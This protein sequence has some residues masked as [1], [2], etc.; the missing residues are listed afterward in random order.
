MT[1]WYCQACHLVSFEPTRP[2]IYTKIELKDIFRSKEIPPDLLKLRSM[3]VGF[4]RPKNDPGAEPMP[5]F[6][7]ADGN[8][9]VEALEKTIGRVEILAWCQ[10]CKMPRAFL[11]VEP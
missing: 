9:E 2:K 4:T 7:I 10:H 5:M 3:F 8:A 11:P 1:L 6:L